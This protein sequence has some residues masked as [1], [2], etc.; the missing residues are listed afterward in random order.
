MEFTAHI[1]RAL[2]FNVEGCCM[3]EEAE[4]AI[5]QAAVAGHNFTSGGMGDGLTYT[6]SDDG[7]SHEVTVTL[8]GVWPVADHNRIE[9][10]EAQ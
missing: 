5:E 6:D 4:D 10:K 7:D 8:T 1:G 2:T 9:I 3:S